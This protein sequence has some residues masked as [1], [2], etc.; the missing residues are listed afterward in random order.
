MRSWAA[1]WI[2]L[3]SLL[4]L[5]VVVT[6]YDCKV[7]VPGACEKIARRYASDFDAISGLTR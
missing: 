1:F 7:G 3:A 4:A 5:Q 6:R 2:G